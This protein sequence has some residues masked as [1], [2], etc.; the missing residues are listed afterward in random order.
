MKKLLF[1]LAFTACL[2][3][4]STPSNSETKKEDKNESETKGPELVVDKDNIKDLNNA[5]DEELLGNFEWQRYSPGVGLSSNYG[6]S[7]YTSG[8]MYSL[9]L[10]FDKGEKY[11]CIN[12]PASSYIDH[13]YFV[14]RKGTDGKFYI[15]YYQEEDDDAEVPYGRLFVYKYCYKCYEYKVSDNYMHFEESAV[16]FDDVYNYVRD[17]M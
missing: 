8:G 3:S 1:V 9:K 15:I 7:F 12:G 16:I 13:N 17:K 14:L 5:T 11:V 6:S 2:I 4:C 10:D